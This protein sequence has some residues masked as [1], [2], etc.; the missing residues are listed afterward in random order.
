LVAKHKNLDEILA[1]ALKTK[2]RSLTSVLLDKNLAKLG[3]AYLNF[4]YSIAASM[5][6]GRACGLRVSNAVLAEA[7]RGSGFRTIL[8]RRLS[9]HDI[10]SSAE[11]LAVYAAANKLFSSQDLIQTLV[12]VEG[13]VEAFTRVFKHIKQ[14]W[15]KTE[16][17]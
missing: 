3:D 14:E 12:E 4:A 6:R 7:M 13:P 15:Q 8:P 16:S 10:G 1:E 17:A 9:R 11:A 2:D 5:T